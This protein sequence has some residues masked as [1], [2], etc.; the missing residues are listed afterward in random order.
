MSEW[1]EKPKRKPPAHCCSSDPCFEKA[2]WGRFLSFCRTHFEELEDV[3]QARSER[4]TVD[5]AKMSN[6]AKRLSP[7]SE[8][9]RPLQTI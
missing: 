8:N 7:R 1:N 3:K 6:G 4:T 2:G 5:A 9:A